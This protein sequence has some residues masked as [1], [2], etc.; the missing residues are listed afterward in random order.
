[1]RSIYREDEQITIT[2]LEELL[3]VPVD[4]L[5]TVLIGNQSTRSYGEWIITPRGYRK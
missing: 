3:N 1:M 4:M 5:T 2:T